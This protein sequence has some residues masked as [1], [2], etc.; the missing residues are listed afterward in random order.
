MDFDDKTNRA[1]LRPV[2]RFELIKRACGITFPAK[3]NGTLLFKSFK[4]VR[5][6]LHVQNRPLVFFPECTRSNG[7]GVL[8]LPSEAVEFVI[9]ATRSENKFALH[10]LRFDYSL[11]SASMQPYNS[12]D[13]LGLKHALVMLAQFLN[14]M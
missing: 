9:E 7:K 10:V 1:G 8:E 4:A 13:V 12:T 5:E 11:N 6:S 2:G 3:V 14:K